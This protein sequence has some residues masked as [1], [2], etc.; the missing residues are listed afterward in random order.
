MVVVQTQFIVHGNITLQI[1]YYIGVVWCTTSS[2]LSVLNGYH[3]QI[4]D[5]YVYSITT[6]KQN[7][8][9]SHEIKKNWKWNIV[10]EWSSHNVGS[11]K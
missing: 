1:P 2:T 5:V 11:K 10:L 3:V 6:N 4:G 7:V 9:F 8:I